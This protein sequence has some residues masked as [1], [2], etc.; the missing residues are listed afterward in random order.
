MKILVNPTHTATAAAA[1]AA[2]AAVNTPLVKYCCY[3]LWV[4]SSCVSFFLPP[5][6]VLPCPP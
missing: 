4:L 6:L 1:A 3:G 5:V 2:A